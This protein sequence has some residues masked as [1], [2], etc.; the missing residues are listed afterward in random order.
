[1]GGGKGFWGRFGWMRLVIVAAFLVSL[2]EWY[3]PGGALAGSGAKGVVLLGFCVALG[4]GW[5][6]FR[7]RILG[8]IEETAVVIGRRLGR[9]VKGNGRRRIRDG[10]AG[11]G[12]AG[13]DDRLDGEDE[14]VDQASPSSRPPDRGDGRLLT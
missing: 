1:M 12:A 3:R 14:P 10:R 2:L 13:H 4:L 11:A 7:P 8:S 9:W 6:L 5:G